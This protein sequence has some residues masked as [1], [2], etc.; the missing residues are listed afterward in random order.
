MD[1]DRLQE[2]ERWLSEQA[3]A[4]RSTNGRLAQLFSLNK[5]VKDIAPPPL[6]L[7]AI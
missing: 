1:I 6:V 2:V 3:E 7:A 5:E 4:T